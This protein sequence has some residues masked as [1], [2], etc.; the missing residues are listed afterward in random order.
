MLYFRSDARFYIL[1]IDEVFIN[2]GIPLP[3]PNLAW[4][5]RNQPIQP[6]QKHERFLIS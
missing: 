3:L 4:H 6:V 5:P 1:S 2:T